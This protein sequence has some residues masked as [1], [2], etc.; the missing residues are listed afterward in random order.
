[1]PESRL[2]FRMQAV[3]RLFQV[4]QVSRSLLEL[5]CADDLQYGCWNGNNALPGKIRKGHAVLYR[6]S[7]LARGILVHKARTEEALLVETALPTT[8]EEVHDFF[9]VLQ[10]L[11]HAYRFGFTYRLAGVVLERRQFR[12]LKRMEQGIQ[13]QNLQ[14]LHRTMQELMQEP[15]RRMRLRGVM[16]PVDLG[17]EEGEQFFQGVDTSRFSAWL[18]DQQKDPFYY[19]DT[20]VHRQDDY[21]NTVL[22]YTISPDKPTILARLPIPPVSILL[23]PKHQ[24]LAVMVVLPRT[25]D[26][27]YT[28]LPYDRFLKH[29]PPELMKPLNSQ[30]LILAPLN[31]E[32]KLTL[33]RVCTQEEQAHE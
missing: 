29:F 2:R 17:T 33:E 3:N 5:L 22:F 27:T 8:Q 12:N 7:R 9:L 24:K 30:D 28:P 18:H 20:I 26:Y 21:H 11:Q 19:A 4:P 13:D 31:T 16:H 25:G 14:L 15:G 10:R 6:S 23:Q 32:Q 1:M